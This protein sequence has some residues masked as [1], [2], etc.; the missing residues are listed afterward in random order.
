MR[1]E[2]KALLRRLRGPRLFD[3]AFLAA[4]CAFYAWWA[5]DELSKQG[6]YCDIGLLAWKALAPLVGFDVGPADPH[7]LTL[8]GR[9]FPLMLLDYHGPAEIYFAMPWIAWLGHTAFSLHIGPVLLG[10]ATIPLFYALQVLIYR[11]R[12][13]AAVNSALLATSISYVVG[14]RL[15]LYAGTLLIFLALAAALCFLQWDRTARL[16]WAAA[17]F[18]WLGAGLGSRIFFVWFALALL[19]FAWRAG[20]LSKLRR[21]TRRQA[22]YCGAA[23][24]VGVLPVLFANIQEPLFSLRFLTKHAVVSSD[25]ISNVLY[26][27]NLLER[28]RHVASLWR[29]NAYSIGRNPLNVGVLLAAWALYLWKVWKERKKALPEKWTRL[30][31]WVAGTTLLLSPL[32]PSGLQ[33]LH[34][35]VAYPFFY[36]TPGSLLAGVRP[37][38]RRLAVRACVALAVVVV[39]RNAAQF[40]FEEAHRRIHGGADV[41]WNGLGAVSDWLAARGIRSVAL[42][43]TGLMDSLRFLTGMKA[44]VT[45]VFWAP[46]LKVP[47]QEAEDRLR[48]RFE[49]ETEGYYLFR[50]PDIRWLDYLPR[51]LEIA[52]DAGKR[53]A[54]EETFLAEDGEPLFVLYKVD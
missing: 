43:D 48:R 51:F 22:V 18:F 39:L 33:P 1:A 17:G 49:A 10:L 26:P 15:G 52:D 53:V 9:S 30:P 8:A 3:A 27:A 5:F 4:L 23:L 36:F 20:L 44:E 25:G 12:P 45:E 35:F 13:A 41:R 29:G 31:L 34:L 7:F 38:F 6:I 40:H 2:A 32:T 11:S 28:L 37:R 46:Y 54:V 19:G 42:G 24:L 50:A 21:F 14:C 47:R 16:G